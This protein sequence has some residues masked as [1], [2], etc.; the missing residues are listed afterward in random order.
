MR[1]LQAMAG[2]EYGGAEAFFVRLVGALERAGVNQQILI[3]ANT[4]R[5]EQLRQ[6]GIEPLQLSFGGKLDWRTPRQ[7]KKEIDV[8]RPDIVLIDA[9]AILES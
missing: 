1:L 4:G 2:A 7:I 6:A 9:V 8:F 3:R 5:A